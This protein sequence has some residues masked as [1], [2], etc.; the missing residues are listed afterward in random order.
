M[1][2]SIILLGVLIILVAFNIGESVY[3]R[4]RIKKR[5]LLIFLTSTFVLYFIPNLKINDVTFTWIGFFLPALFSVIVLLRVK[6]AKIYFAMFVSAL[7]SFT[8]NI[9]YNLITF[10]VYESAIF[11]PYL[12]LAII[13][14]TIPLL[15]VKTPSRL[16]AS[17][18]VGIIMSEIIFYMSRY[19]IY[20]EQY[21]IVGSRKTFE[22]LL[23]SFVLSVF[24]CFV[25]RKVKI[26]SIRRK[27]AKKERL[28]ID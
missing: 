16:Y 24:S 15:L 12:V 18:F 17:N 26:I 10:D 14:G 1:T 5:T 9:I 22:T 4:L 6:N 2:F 27:I 19:A 28:A 25:A 20:G 3:K 7:L 21:L 23:L 11:Q 8:L 13:L